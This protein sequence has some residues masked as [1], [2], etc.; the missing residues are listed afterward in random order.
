MW[1]M[2]HMPTQSI[3]NFTRRGSAFLLG[4]LAFLSERAELLYKGVGST[5]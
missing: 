4:A 2:C 1:K 5:V 3:S